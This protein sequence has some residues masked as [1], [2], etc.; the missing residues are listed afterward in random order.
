MVWHI[1]TATSTLS[2]TLKLS[3]LYVAYKTLVKII[4]LISA[5][6]HIIE[7]RADTDIYSTLVKLVTAETKNTAETK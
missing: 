2:D 5:L 3:L 4:P 1:A 7:L 6:F